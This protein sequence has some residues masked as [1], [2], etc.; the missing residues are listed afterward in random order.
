MKYLKT[1]KHFPYKDLLY[2]AL[3]FM[4]TVALIV[5]FLPREGTFNYQFDI[6][7]PWK[8]GQLMATFDFPIYKDDAVVKHEQ[9]SILAFFQP[10]YQLD[11]GIEKKAI[12]KL[13]EN[14]KL[15]LNKVVPS[16]NYIHHI[17]KTIDEL[18]KVGIVSTEDIKKIQKDNTSSI[19]VVD[20]KL[21]NQRPTKGL[22][23]VKSAY[24]YLLSADT[25]HH[26]KEVLRRCAL[27]EYISPNLSFDEQRTKTAKKDILDD[28]SWANGVVQSGQKIID[29][30]EIVDKKMYN[31]LTSLRKESIKRSESIGQK[32][33][34]LGGQILFIGILMLCFMLYLELFRKDYYERKGSLPLLF[35]LIIFYCVVTALMIR[36]NIFSVYVIPYAMLP[37]ITRIFLDSRTAFL[38]HVITILACSITLRYP[39][40]F[41]LLQLTAGLIAIYSLRELSQRSQLFRTAFLV[42]LTYVALYFSFELIT[43][44]DLSKLNT[45]MY[46]YFVIN[47]ILLLFTYP[48]LFLFE[49]VFSFTSNVTLV[50]LSNINNHLLRKLSETVPG[51]FQHSL[52]VANLAA[53]AAIRVD[54]KS[55]LVRTGAL[56]HDIGKMENPAFFT[57]NQSSGINPHEKLSYEQSAQIVISHVTDGLRLA[58]KNNLPKAIRDFITTHHGRGKTKFFYISWKNEHPNEEPDEELF[59]YPGPNPFSKETAILMMADGVEA[60][61]RSLPEY[62]EESIS[63]LV[64]KIIDSQVDEGYFKECP[65]TFKDISTIKDVFKEKLRTIYHT[66]ISY[67]ELKK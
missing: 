61:S 54:A 3:I 8:Y 27:N 24:E 60:A 51:T 43:E 64:E 31:I 37:V 1:K 66:R 12:K 7:K 15:H 11:K 38:A 58:E 25:L 53:E 56:Y 62:T 42:I 18:Y 50:E 30:G 26:K 5:Y 52:Q 67:P 45:S 59:T 21:A 6:N 20:S 47:G 48:L 19:M 63:N 46:T 13:K 17:E 49:K 55:Q 10:Y 32:Q 41:I 44:S 4:G 40:E 57:E 23:T 22:F 35:S 65:I 34:I 16:V 14:F 28:Y 36:N 29:R 2:K 9:D 39:H 33:V